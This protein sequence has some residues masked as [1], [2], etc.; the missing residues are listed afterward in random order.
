MSATSAQRGAGAAQPPQ[1]GQAGAPIDLTGYWVAVVTED[2]R[3]RMGTP[4]KGDYASVPLND[5]GKKAADA[6]TPSTA[7]SCLNYGAAGLMRNPL[8]LHVTWEN[9]ST[10]KLESDH[11]M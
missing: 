11:G 4:P 8:R 1:S 10:L 7:D 6:W 9:D 2:W 5:A 3:W